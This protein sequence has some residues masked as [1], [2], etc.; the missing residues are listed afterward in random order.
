MGEKERLEPML[1]GRE[2]KEPENT[3]NGFSIGSLWVYIVI[4]LIVALIYSNVTSP[5]PD[6]DMYK[7]HIDAQRG[8]R[9]EIEREDLRRER[10]G[11]TPLSKE[12][13]EDIS[14]RHVMREFR[15]QT[16]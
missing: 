4:A 9:A 12:E 14:G 13:I 11:E 2:Y 1:E 7:L 8:T 16:Q 15:K 10:Y 5:T 6:V 3:D